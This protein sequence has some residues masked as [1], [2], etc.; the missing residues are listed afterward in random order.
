MGLTLLQ[1][2]LHCLKQG[3]AVGPLCLTN[4]SRLGQHS[5]HTPFSIL[6]ATQALPT[7]TRHVVPC[8]ETL[9]LYVT[10]FFFTL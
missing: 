2:Q 9:T 7:N 10:P 5:I 6:H 8:A 3:T 1:Q 4:Q